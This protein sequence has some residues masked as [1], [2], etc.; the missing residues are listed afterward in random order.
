MSEPLLL[1]IITYLKGQGLVEG[2]GID[3]FRDIKPSSPDDIIALYEYQGSPVSPFDTIT[4]RSVQISVRSASADASKEKVMKIFK[5]FMTTNNRR[6]DFT[7]DR[8]GQMYLRQTPFLVS[9][10]ANNLVTY[11]FNM[12]ITTNLD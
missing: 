12:G 4:H 7:P 3:A 10:D 11:G 8:W 2:D 9:R 1:D 6:I 5:S